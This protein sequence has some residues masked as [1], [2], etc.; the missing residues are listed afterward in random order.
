MEVIMSLSYYKQL[1]PQRAYCE[2]GKESK[3][4]F[5]LPFP[6][7]VWVHIKFS[8]SVALANYQNNFYSDSVKM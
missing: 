5:L 1:T 8:V 6:S 4:P 3:A 2:L 7:L